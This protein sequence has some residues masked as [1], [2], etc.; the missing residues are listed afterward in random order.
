MPLTLSQS[1]C[2]HPK[3]HDG[4]HDCPRSSMSS[5]RV[6]SA[7]TSMKLDPSAFKSLQQSR[8]FRIDGAVF[9]QPGFVGAQIPASAHHTLFMFSIDKLARALTNG[10]TSCSRNSC[11]NSQRTTTLQVRASQPCP[12]RAPGCLPPSLR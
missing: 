10:P 3:K 11:S 4:Y 1:A 9:G 12:F 5:R 2:N 8:R 6:Q 7:R